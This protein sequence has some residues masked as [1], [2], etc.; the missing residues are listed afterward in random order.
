MGSKLGE[1]AVMKVGVAFHESLSLDVNPFSAG[2]GSN[3]VARSEERF[4]EFSCA[5][6]K[7]GW[8]SR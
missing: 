4:R 8:F 7:I 6:G 3:P 2:D 5:S 1:T